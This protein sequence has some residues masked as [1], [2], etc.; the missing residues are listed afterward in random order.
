MTM[1]IFNPDL[2]IHN[3]Q[4]TYR[5]YW[6]QTAGHD[7]LKRRALRELAWRGARL[8]KRYENACSHTWAATE[9]A[10]RI[11][12]GLEGECVALARD[13]GLSV[14]LQ[15][16]PRGCTVYVG[17]EELTSRNYSVLGVPL[18]YDEEA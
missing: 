9:S 17:R 1:H 8:R 13:A 12:E 15:T 10:S 7:M 14:Y 4:G 18:F 5:R 3:E 2:P 11:T 6:L 16:D